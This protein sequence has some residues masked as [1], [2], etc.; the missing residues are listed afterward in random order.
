MRLSSNELDCHELSNSLCSI[1]CINRSV[2]LGLLK[3]AVTVSQQLQRLPLLPLLRVGF[4][5]FRGFRLAAN[6]RV[7]LS[8]A[9]RSSAKYFELKVCYESF[10]LRITG[11]I[12][13]C[14]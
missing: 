5:G 9:H 2:A 6:D 7:R 13:M 12:E 10:V 14:I 8:F 1:C 3:T 4:F 11:A